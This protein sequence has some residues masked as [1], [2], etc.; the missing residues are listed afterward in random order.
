MLASQSV[1]AANTELDVVN[2]Q[3]DLTSATTFGG[4]TPTAAN[5]ITFT[6]VTYSPAAFTI[7]GN[8]T[9]NF[10]TLNDLSAT[11]LTLSNGTASTTATLNLGGG[12]GDSVS[13]SAS[14]DLLYVASGGTLTIQN[15]TGILNLALASSGNF[16]VAGTATISSVISGTGF[17][18]TKTGA[19][20]LTL[21]GTNTFTGGLTVNA[22][23]VSVGNV[24]ANLGGTS[25]VTLDGATATLKTTNTAAS[26]N[27]THTVTIG[28]SGGT[29]NIA[30][31]AT[32]SQNSRVIFNT[33]NALT[34]S[35][36]LTVTGAG[37]L[38]TATG[39]N[40]R[41]G[42]AGALV[43]SS[44]NNYSGNITLQNGGLIE[45]GNAT[46]LSPTATITLGNEA[47]FAVNSAVVNQ[48]VTVSGGTNSVLSFA[49][50][51]PTF[52]GNVTMNADLL[53]GL[54]NWYTPSS[55]VNTA[56]NG[57]ISGVISGAGN[58]STAGS[59][60][61]STA[62]TLTL[63]GANTYTGNTSLGAN[64][65]LASVMPVSRTYAGVI[66][67]SGSF[68]KDGPG[69]LTLT[70]TNTY[71]G[72]TTISYGTVN[73]GNGTIGSMVSTPLTFSGSG[74]TI[75]FNEAAGSSQSMGAL[76]FSAGE[77]NVQSTYGGSG[78]TSL[79]FS[80]VVARSAGA[81]ANFVVSGGTTTGATPTN[82][83]VFTQ[84]AGATPT[85]GALLD[86]GYFFGGSNYAAYDANGYVRDYQTGDTNAASSGAGPSTIANTST[87]NVFLTGADTAQTTATV[88]TIN[89]GN[90]GT[91]A[92]SAS[93]TLSTNGLLVSG[94]NAA[95]ISGGTGASLNAATAGGELVIRTDL[96]TDNLDISTPIVN[97]T[98][99]S[100]LTKSGAG[101]LTLS[102]TGNSYSGAT[103][104]DAGTLSLSGTLTGG[105]A[106]TVKSGATFSE[107]SGGVISGASTFTSSGTSTLAGANTYTGAT[108][109][110][111]GTLNYTGTLTN[112]AAAITVGNTVSSAVMNIGSSGTIKGTTV[113][114]GS[115]NAGSA[116]V[117]QTSGT[118]TNTTTGG[119][120]FQI[121]SATGAT[122]YYN[123]SGG[124]INLGGEIDPGGSSGGAGTF[125]QFD[126]SGGTVNLPNITGSYFLPNR[127]AAGEAAVVNISGGT[128]QITGSGTPAATTINGLTANWG[129]GSQNAQIT[130]S[131]TGQ[132]ITPSLLVKLNDSANTTNVA[133]LNL[134]TGTTGGTLQTLGFGFA[135]NQ[136]ASPTGNVNAVVNFNGGTLKAG[137]AGNNSFLTGLGAANVYSGGGTIDNN[138][139]A[140]TISQALL[141]ASGTGVSSVAVSAAGSGYTAAPRVV[142]SGGTLTGG[143]ASNQATGYATFDP[144]TGAVT[145]IV[146]T[147]PGSYTSTTGLTVALSGGNGRGTTLGTL[148]L[149]SGNTSGGMTFAG[150]GTTTLTGANTYNGTTV[151]AG[152]VTVGTGGT[153]GATTGALA[154]NNANTGAGTNVVLN[155]AT[156][157]D[158]TT[159]SLSGTLASPSSG[160]NTAT[161]NNGG[162]GR[163]FT[164]N[165]TTA[166]T[167][168]GVIAGAGS[169]T[170]GS[171]S[172]NTL[173]LSG[174]NTYTG[175]TTIN[176]GTLA[177]GAADRL[178][179]SSAMTL[180]GGTFAT[181][182]F[183]QT[184]NTLTLS[185]SST[186]D[187]GSGTSALV[188]ADSSAITWSG[189]L[190]LTN[191]DVGTDSLKFG[192]SSIGLT[193]TQLSD[194][195]IAGYTV[196]GLDSSGF[197]QV[198]AIPEPAT[199][200]AIFGGLVLVGAVIRRRRRAQVV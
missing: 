121:G 191:F 74:G 186:L 82:K 73:V 159:G 117:Y 65:T 175:A 39:V 189:T 42:G 16:D 81:T 114:I 102:G 130:I 69:T 125:G 103:T 167:Y 126:M 20:T 96:S 110:S 38:G 180:N 56:Q 45:Y 174:T 12:T 113:L 1:Q 35:G 60:T 188:F 152:T 145:G 200:A 53:I 184:L 178:S 154:V 91:I 70:G 97:N 185:S 51:A 109:V 83:I 72:T 135:I 119:G 112:G 44:S 75:N 132:F 198:S 123:L 118:L 2:G 165:Q 68:T 13:G 128:V 193:A 88:N 79:T 155:L 77:A 66:S 23:V 104:V 171:A 54:R 7:S 137:T 92:L 148:T 147:N 150:T 84:V 46:A 93:Q 108:T 19:G 144:T 182:G 162:S 99:A 27:T 52:A 172:T 94:N 153:L 21:S 116:A 78:N 192:S 6:A 43:L 58:L 196:T 67:G 111:A 90:T 41:F 28:A 127:G 115:S 142:F 3:S 181:G 22:G 48:N 37:T 129:A 9:V 139:Q 124:V 146:I 100:A 71:T 134:G 64:T 25:P 195:S 98:S 80:N 76:T 197:L 33:T 151:N 149:N 105:G 173:T 158:T 55:N 24:V 49:T 5:D 179:S 11:A 141:G 170:L 190:T 156:A 61:A 107:T 138:G 36:A 168:A 122:A 59:T 160:T 4:T 18:I 89:M 133:T 10:G 40:T 87:N 101:T 177:L 187:F 157:V 199:Y 194:I 106:I 164:V 14:G 183:N 30:G 95:T 63:T 17:G 143:L 131:G 34:G 62:V 26:T 86:K 169:F 31:T 8:S 140:I 15:G 47:E 136:G 120:G 57:T 85:T 163:N 29:I 32:A 166:G 161:I 50:N 176:A